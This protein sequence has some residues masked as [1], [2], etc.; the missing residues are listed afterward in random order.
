MGIA[1]M[2]GVTGLTAVTEIVFDSGQLAR[3]GVTITVYT[4][5]VVMPG[6]VVGV[7][8]VFCKVLLPP[9]RK[10]AGDHE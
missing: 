6:A 4:I 1:E 10:V 9:I 5:V 7:I 3:L 2:V 8:I